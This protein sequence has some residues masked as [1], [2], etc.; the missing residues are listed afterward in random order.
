MLPGGLCQPASQSHRDGHWFGGRHEIKLVLSHELWHSY[1]RSSMIRAEHKATST[2]ITAPSGTILNNLHCV[3]KVC[4][5]I[6]I[7]ILYS[8]PFLS[9]CFSLNGLTRGCALSQTSLTLRCPTSTPT[10]QRQIWS[11]LFK[12]ERGQGKD[13]VLYFHPQKRREHIT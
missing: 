10:I 2:A 13:Q 1:V 12:P 4:C 8:P 3:S 7:T 11:L 9:G 5:C 6:F